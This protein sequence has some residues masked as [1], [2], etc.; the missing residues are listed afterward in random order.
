M[1]PG[2]VV[3]PTVRAVAQVGGSR[4]VANDALLNPA[5]KPGL[6]AETDR[7]CRLALW[8]D[9]YA[10]RE[11]LAIRALREWYGTGT[12]LP[13]QICSDARRGSPILIEIGSTRDNRLAQRFDNAMGFKSVTTHAVGFGDV[14]CPKGLSDALIPAIGGAET[15]G[16]AGGV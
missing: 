13:R 5:E 2:P 3:K 4:I 7:R 14:I 10:V 9:A 16:I 12:R 11:V 8:T 6:L 15:T 1:D